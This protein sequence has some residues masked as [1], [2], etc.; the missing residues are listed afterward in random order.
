MSFALSIAAIDYPVTRRTRL[1]FLP[2]NQPTP[3]GGTL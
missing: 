3:Q 1:E 2:K